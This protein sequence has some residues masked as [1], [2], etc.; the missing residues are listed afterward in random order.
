M[1]K[2]LITNFYQFII[3]RFIRDRNKL[4]KQFPNV[5]NFLL[6]VLQM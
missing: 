3:V 2:K 4:L 5:M 6:Q 1:N